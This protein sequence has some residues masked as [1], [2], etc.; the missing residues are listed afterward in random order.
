MASEIKELTQG[1]SIKDKIICIVGCGGLGTN[2]AVHIAG[3][4]AGRIYL[5]DYDKVVVSNLNRQFF[6]TE[7][8]VGKSK[9][10]V[11]KEKLSLYAPDTEF[12][13]A[14]IKIDSEESLSFAAG[15]DVIICAVDNAQAR[16]VLSGFAKR[17]NIPLVFGSIEGFYGTAYLYVPLESPCPICAGIINDVSVGNSVSAVAGIIGSMQ[18]NLAIRYLLTGDNSLAGKVFLFDGDLWDTLTVRANK[19]CKLCNI[20]EV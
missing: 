3:A 17:E 10:S 4:G 14:D 13:S 16:N 9:C 12:V 18:A 8:D 11:L 20:H 2:I 15:C 19:N 7:K 6:Y 1:F 5:C